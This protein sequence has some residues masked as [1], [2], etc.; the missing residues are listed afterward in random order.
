MVGAGDTYSVD[1]TGGNLLHAHDFTGAGHTHDLPAGTDLQLV[2][3]GPP[4]TNSIAATG[5]TDNGSS[6][7]PYH[8]LVLVMYDGRLL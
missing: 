6:L 3:I 1:D 7:P 2:P 4:V 8:S 5:T